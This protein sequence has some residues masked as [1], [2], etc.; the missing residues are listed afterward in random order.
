VGIG[1]KL[2]NGRH[3]VRDKKEV[4]KEKTINTKQGKKKKEKVIRD[5]QRGTVNQDYEAESVNH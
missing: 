4:M 2:E 5:K 3:G 1:L